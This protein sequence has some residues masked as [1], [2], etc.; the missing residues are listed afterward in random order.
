[1]DAMLVTATRH[2]N[3]YE[4]EQSAYPSRVHVVRSLGGPL[5][6]VIMGLLMLPRPG[7]IARAFAAFNLLAGAIEVAPIETVDG[8]VIWRELAGW[9]PSA[10]DADPAS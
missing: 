5:A 8:G 10:G 4:G 6:N 2:I 9:Q 1:M 3:L 7:W